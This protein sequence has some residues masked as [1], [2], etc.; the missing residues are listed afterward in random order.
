VAWGV[1]GGLAEGE[2][3]D[4]GGARRMMVVVVAGL[5]G[6]VEADFCDG[7]GWSVGGGGVRSIA[8]V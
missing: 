2:G 4:V 3:G 8:W 5:E 1:R 7:H 6:G